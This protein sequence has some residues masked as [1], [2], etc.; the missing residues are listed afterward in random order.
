MSINEGDSKS[1][2]I[3]YGTYHYSS[4]ETYNSDLLFDGYT[5]FEADIWAL[6]ITFYNF[7]YFKMPFKGGCLDELAE[8]IENQK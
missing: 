2:N 7:I 4:P 6:G 1:N 3:G 8:S 5:G